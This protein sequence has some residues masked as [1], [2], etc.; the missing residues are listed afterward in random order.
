VNEKDSRVNAKR[1]VWSE[2]LI[3]WLV[4]LC[5]TSGQTLILSAHID[6]WAIQAPLTFIWTSAGY[7]GFMTLVFCL[8]IRRIRRKTWG[9][10]MQTLS[11]AA[12]RVANGDFSVHIAPLRKDGKKDYVEVM[13]DDFNRMVEELDSIETLTGDFVSNVS[14]EIKTP[15]SVIQSYATA[16]QKME[17][18]RITRLEYTNTIITAAQHLNTLIT[19]ILKLSKLETQEFRQDKREYDLCAQLAE[20]ALQFEEQWEAKSI[21]FT[22]DMENKAMICADAELTSI[23]WNNLLSNA[24]KF[25]EPGGAVTL[26]QTS[27]EKAIAVSVTDTGCGMS[28]ATMARIFDKFYQ[29][30]TSHSQEGNGLGLAL[31]KRVIELLDGRIFVKS[32]PGEGSTF[33]AILK[34]AP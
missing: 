27:D 30:D 9:D 1:R 21:T 34:A 25:T 6:L 2:Y 4:M 19:N 12:R 5:L 10:P 11:S 26:S 8:M 7:W 29:G 17:T 28:E 13:F 22:A 32:S 18:D 24:L 16:I 3:I 31:T 20:C 15:L 14:H 23:V 33:T